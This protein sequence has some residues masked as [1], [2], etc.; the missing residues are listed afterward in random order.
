MKSIQETCHLVC[1]LSTCT[2]RTITFTIY[3]VCL[4]NTTEYY[5]ILADTTGYYRILPILPN[6]TEYYRY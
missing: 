1:D 4:P 3:T 6:T 5:R 2:L